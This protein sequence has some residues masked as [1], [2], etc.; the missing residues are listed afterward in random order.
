MNEIEERLSRCFSAVFP[1]LPES[2]IP[3]ATAGAIEGWD[4][5]ATITL[6]SVIEEEFGIE[7]DPE[8]IEHFISFETVFEYLSSKSVAR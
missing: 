1:D 5:M 8:D 3:L 6:V 4:S 2:D 7:I